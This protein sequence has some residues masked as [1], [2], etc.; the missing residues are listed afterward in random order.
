MRAQ[1]A[2]TLAA[3]I[4]AGD[5]ELALS[6]GALH[7]G[8]QLQTRSAKDRLLVSL[9]GQSGFNTDVAMLG[10]VLLVE[11]WNCKKQISNCES[12]ILNGTLMK[13]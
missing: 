12:V 2:P 13:E 5:T 4:T 11:S 7:C 6:F 10:H 8:G 3:P 9:E 1:A